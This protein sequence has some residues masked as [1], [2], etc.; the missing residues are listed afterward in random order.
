MGSTP[1]RDALGQLLE[2]T[3]AFDDWRLRS[4]Q[5]IADYTRLREVKRLARQAMTS[6]DA[7]ACNDSLEFIAMNNRLVSLLRQWCDSLEDPMNLT[8]VRQMQLR[9]ATEEL[10]GLYDGTFAGGPNAEGNY[11]PPV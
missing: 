8:T 10:I 4:R 6:A 3:K 2:A 1:I 5:T 9:A 7:Q 11:D